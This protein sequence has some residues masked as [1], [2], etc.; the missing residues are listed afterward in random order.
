MNVIKTNRILGI[1]FL[2]MEELGRHF[3]VKKV[4]FDIIK[5]VNI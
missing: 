5:V 2:K 1:I 4:Y 3:T